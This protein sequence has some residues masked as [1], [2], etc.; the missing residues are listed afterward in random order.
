ML[1][2]LNAL[3]QVPI[4]GRFPMLVTRFEP[5]LANGTVKFS[6]FPPNRIPHGLS[7]DENTVIKFIC[8]YAIPSLRT[9][10]CFGFFKKGSESN[11]PFEGVNIC[12][13]QS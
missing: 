6:L 3:L 2:L 1:G 8:N 7:I 13:N 11:D 9:T 5:V 4:E 10:L 12:N